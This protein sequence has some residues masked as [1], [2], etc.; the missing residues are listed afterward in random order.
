MPSTFQLPAEHVVKLKQV[1]RDLH[2]LLAEFDLATE[3]GIDCNEYR[4]MHQEASKSVNAILKNYGP[5]SE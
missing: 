1:Q 2:D 3:C 5:P 4:R